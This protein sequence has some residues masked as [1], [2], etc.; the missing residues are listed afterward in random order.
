MAFQFLMEVFKI[1][2]QDRVLR[3]LL[4]LQLVL[5]MTRLKGFFSHFSPISKKSATLPPRSDV[6]MVLEEEEE[7]EEGLTTTLSTWSSM[8]AGGGAS[9]S[10]LA[11]S[12]AGG[13]PRQTGPRLAITIWHPW[14]IGSGPG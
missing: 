12:I 4:T 1:F 5:R 7:S 3:H 9:G 10:R 2:A 14:L 13:W 8:G 6:P 11:S